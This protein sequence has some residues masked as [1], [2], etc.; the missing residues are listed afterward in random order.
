MAVP[1]YNAATD[2]FIGLIHNLSENN[3]L[4]HFITEMVEIAAN[5][6]TPQDVLK[7]AVNKA[8]NK[9]NEFPDEIK[10]AYALVLCMRLGKIE[11][12]DI[13]DEITKMII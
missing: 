1:Y 6:A 4:P 13:A 9:L 12:F 7:A 3:Q 11:R 2:E 5:N 10:R 8:A